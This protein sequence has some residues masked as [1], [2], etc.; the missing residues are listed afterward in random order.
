LQGGQDWQVT[1]EDDLPHW[2]DA[3]DRKENAEITVYDNVNH[4]LQPSE[5]Q[6]TRAEYALDRSV[7]ERIIRDIAAFVTEPTSDATQ[8]EP[9]LLS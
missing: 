4:I 8:R 1:V 5:G 3:L 7:D 2:R 6:R 9:A